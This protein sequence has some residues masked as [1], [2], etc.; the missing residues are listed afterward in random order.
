[1]AV[2]QCLYRVFRKIIVT[3]YWV[4]NNQFCNKDVVILYKK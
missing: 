4:T 1:M 3:A 2:T